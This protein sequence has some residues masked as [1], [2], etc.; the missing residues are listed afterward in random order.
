MVVGGVVFCPVS[1]STTRLHI[2]VGPIK[3]TKVRG[4]GAKEYTFQDC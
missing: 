3:F 1:S 2:D 4:K